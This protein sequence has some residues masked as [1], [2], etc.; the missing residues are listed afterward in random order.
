[1]AKFGIEFVPEQPFW[2][3][4]FYAIQAEKGGFENVWIT[5]HF[6]NRNP[7][8]TMAAIANYT[9]SIKLGVG[10]TNP[11]LVN[12]VVT[13]QAIGSLSEIAPGRVILGMGA[14]DKT[15]L[16][17]LGSE[18]IKPLKAV[19]ESVRIARALLARERL[20]FDGEIFNVQNAKFAFR[21]V[22]EIPIYVGAQGPKMLRLAAAIG[23][24][25]LIN[26]AH[27][28]DI[29]AA[30]KHIRA[31]AEK[32][33]R[34][35]SDLDITVYASFSIHRDEEEAKKATLPVVAFIVAGSPEFLLQRHG[36]DEE[37]VKKVKMA[38]D[39]AKWGEAF[40]SVTPK[41]IKA[42]SI[43]GNPDKCA[44]SISQFLDLGI[45]QFVVGSPIGP[46][47]RESIDILSEDVIPRFRRGG[48]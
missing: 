14:G 16:R 29:E 43:T 34:K 32:A 26:A 44:E 6:M 18:M 36:I 19:K 4:V 30:L 17:L 8:T 40:S 45:T 39:A 47:T 25:V 33:G 38:L 12:P 20:S 11:Y 28:K 41:M 27:P 15:T 7:Y 10:V 23:D 9:D 24:G 1:M 35:L 42:F 2:K 22:G 21:P 46:N 3:T 48:V 31:G 13:A 37:R 5:D